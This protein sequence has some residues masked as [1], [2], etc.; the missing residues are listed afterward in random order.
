MA[1]G[2]AIA[3]RQRSGVDRRTIAHCGATSAGGNVSLAFAAQQGAQ[4]ESESLIRA[5]VPVNRLGRES[6][7]EHF[8]EQ[9]GDLFRAKLQFQFGVDETP[10]QQSELCPLIIGREAAAFSHVVSDKTAVPEAGSITSELAK[11][12]CG[13]HGQNDGNFPF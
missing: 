1:E 3:E 12:R 11:D 7:S 5:D 10:G 2:A 8:H 13:M 6:V 4:A 9:G